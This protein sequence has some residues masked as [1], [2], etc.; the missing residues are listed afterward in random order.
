MRANSKLPERKRCSTD[1]HL[2][3]TRASWVLF[4]VVLA[5]VC[6]AQRNR[7]YAASTPAGQCSEP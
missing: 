3:W 6:A 5:L 7:P 1:L 4:P 2:F